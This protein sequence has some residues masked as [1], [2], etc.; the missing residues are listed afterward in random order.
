VVSDSQIISAPPRR[1]ARWPLVVGGMILGL[2]IGVLL[3]PFLAARAVLSTPL[4]RLLNGRSTR[5]DTS[6]ASV[7]DKIRQLNRL[8]SVDYSIDKIVEG[9]HQAQG[10]PDFL[11]GDRLLL[12]AHGEV[13]AGVDLSRLDPKAVQV[14]GNTVHVRLPEPQ[15]LVTRIDN[16]RTRVYERTT[17]ILVP[18]D[19]NL[20]TQ[21]R[22]AAEQQITQAA[23]DDKILDKARQNAR[24]SVTGLL[25]ALGF[26]TVDVQ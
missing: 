11:A 17:G 19:P 1:R 3:I 26:H 9:N 14:N 5:I 18:T 23:I 7:V 2:I 20:E 16:T 8:E 13:I 22:Q 21:V 25:Y 4:G 15:V 24:V 6:S 12:I 10:L